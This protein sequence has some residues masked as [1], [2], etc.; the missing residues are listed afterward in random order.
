MRRKVFEKEPFTVAHQV[1]HR[2]F[3]PQLDEIRIT[4]MRDLAIPAFDT[5][6]EFAV[7]VFPLRAV[8]SPPIN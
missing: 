6:K 3:R 8:L 7:A 1:R 4:P 5:F 2:K